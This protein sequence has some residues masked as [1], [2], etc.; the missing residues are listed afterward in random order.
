MSA[1]D[2]GAVPPA[3]GPGLPGTIATV[4]RYELPL[5]REDVW[6][7]ISDVSRYRTW[8]P[9]LRSF[10]AVVLAPD[11]QWQCVVQPPMP[12]LVRFGVLIE[13]VDRAVLVRATVVG[14]VVGTATLTLEDSATG[15]AV[16]LDSA[17]A[18]GNKALR[19]VSRFAA[20][21][22][23]YGHDW[24]LDSGA[25]QFITRAVDPLVGGGTPLP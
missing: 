5:P 4:H 20:P 16:T 1:E 17:L 23:R 2:N 8:W 3:A 25:R 15:C 18:P 7:L 22:A 19:L 10:D 9:W 12:Y 21:V 14:D 11:Q 13:C 24:V 6:S